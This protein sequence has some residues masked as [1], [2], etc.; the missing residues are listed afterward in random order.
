[1]LM[2]VFKSRCLNDGME[3]SEYTMNTISHLTCN[4]AGKV[5]ERADCVLPTHTHVLQHYLFILSKKDSSSVKIIATVAN[6]VQQ[7]R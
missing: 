6:H 4:L 2:I 3:I 7:V 5:A 1:M